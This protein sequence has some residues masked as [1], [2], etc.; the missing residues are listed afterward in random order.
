MAFAVLDFWGAEVFIGSNDDPK[1]NTETQKLMRGAHKIP[2]SSTGSGS[3]SKKYTLFRNI[4]SFLALSKYSF[5]NT[6]Q[7]DSL[8]TSKTKFQ[9]CIQFFFSCLTVTTLVFEEK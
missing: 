5:P 6:S 4:C 8:F 9:Y 1:V 2:L 3:F 7:N